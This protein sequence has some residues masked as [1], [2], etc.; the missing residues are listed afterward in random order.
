ML[1]GT[2]VV[3]RLFEYFPVL[4]IIKPA[5]FSNIKSFAARWVDYDPRTKKW[6]GLKPY[7]KNAFFEM[8]NP[9][10]FGALDHLYPIFQKRMPDAT[11]YTDDFQ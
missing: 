2:P 11:V 8:T 6:L 10:L 9:I 3:N 7:A 1:S 5:H 4:N